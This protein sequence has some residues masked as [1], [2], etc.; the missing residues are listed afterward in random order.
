MDAAGS[1]EAAEGFAK[2]GGTSFRHVAALAEETR[3]WHMIEVFHCT[4]VHILIL[5]F[6]FLSNNDIKNVEFL[7]PKQT[8]PTAL[9]RRD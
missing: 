8:C 1:P 6:M 4:R 5:R 3:L 7:G 2:D 9:N